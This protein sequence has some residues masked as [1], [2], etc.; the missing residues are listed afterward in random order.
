[1]AVPGCCSVCFM[2]R[3]GGGKQILEQ[4][5]RES[6]S[7]GLLQITLMLG[8]C[9]EPGYVLIILIYEPFH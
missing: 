2:F 4:K 8:K 3:N 6:V 5:V 7:L 1:M 9:P